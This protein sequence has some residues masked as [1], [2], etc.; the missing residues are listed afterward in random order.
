MSLRLDDVDARAWEDAGRGFP[1]KAVARGAE[2]VRVDRPLAIP[3]QPGENVFLVL[4][5]S[6]DCRLAGRL[7]SLASGVSVQIQGAA[8]PVFRPAREG[9]LVLLH[10]FPAEPAPR[11]GGGARGEAGPP[12]PASAPDAWQGLWGWLARLLGGRAS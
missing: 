5:G 2:L 4:R 6:G 8:A 9:P 7:V 1:H 10:L 3:L 12:A 11:E